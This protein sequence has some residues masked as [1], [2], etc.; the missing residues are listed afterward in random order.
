VAA[1]FGGSGAGAGAGDE[2]VGAGVAL[3]APSAVAA[4]V[5]FVRAARRARNRSNKPALANCDI[6]MT[7]TRA[8]KKLFRMF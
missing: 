1:G 7:A 2:V 3:P 6:T 4:A 8:M 5:E